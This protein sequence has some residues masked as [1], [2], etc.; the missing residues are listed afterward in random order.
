MAT[1]SVTIKPEITYGIKAPRAAYLRF[2]LGHNFGEAERPEQQT[3]IL[4]DV[5]KMVPAFPKPVQEDGHGT[6]V[7]LPYRWR[8]D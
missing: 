5:L 2:P 6:I 3:E 1:A 7:R 4:T 8:I